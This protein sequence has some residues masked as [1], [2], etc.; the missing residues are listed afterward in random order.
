MVRT[1]GGGVS[2]RYVGEEEVSLLGLSLPTTPTSYPSGPLRNY[3]GPK[4]RPRVKSVEVFHVLALGG[5]GGGHER[6]PPIT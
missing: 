5:P 3:P 6:R 1:T 2:L 4:D